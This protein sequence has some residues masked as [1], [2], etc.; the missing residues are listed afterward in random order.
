[1]LY[2]LS[3]RIVLPIFTHNGNGIG[4]TP[5]RDKKTSSQS[6]TAAHGAAHLQDPSPSPP[7]STATSTSTCTAC[8]RSPA[9][10][11]SALPSPSAC[12]FSSS[13]SR[14]SGTLP[15]CLRRNFAT[16]SIADRGIVRSWFPSLG[17][18]LAREPLLARN[19][20]GAAR[21]VMIGKRG[22]KGQLRSSGSGRVIGGVS[23][24][25]RRLD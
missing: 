9:R 6:T 11:T 3:Q 8:R 7:R 19:R 18:H 17:V 4:E 22:R 5:L 14:S 16:T 25:R 1:M 15:P 2:C 23:G 21:A 10:P 12:R 20:R 13:P 24:Q